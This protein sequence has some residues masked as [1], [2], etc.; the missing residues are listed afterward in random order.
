MASNRRVARSFVL[1]NG[2]VP[3]RKTT[4]GT[5]TKATILRAAADLASVDGLEGLTIGGLASALGMSKSG[6]FAHFG[7]KEELQLATIEAARQV[8]VAEVIAPALAGPAGIARVDALCEAFLSYVER[9]VFPGGCFFAAAMAE[10]DCKPG[11][12]RDK[13]AEL[14][15]AWMHTLE[16]AAAAAVEAGELA[17]TTDPCQLAFDL[18]AA[19]LGANWYLHLFSD[20]SYLE[21][22]RHSVRREL[23]QAAAAPGRCQLHN[24]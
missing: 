20:A 2:L 11:P 5:R 1:Y 9:E 14:Q 15:A 17:P 8:Y 16:A 4:Q 19:M 21:R 3:V 10:F 13:I 12:V 23:T 24:R 22:A 7:S 18:E 6:L